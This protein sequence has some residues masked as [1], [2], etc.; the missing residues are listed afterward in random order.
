MPQDEFNSLMS[1]EKG[2]SSAWESALMACESL[3][4]ISENMKTMTKLNTTHETIVK[5][6]SA[7]NKDLD[8]FKVILVKLE[9]L[10]DALMMFLFPL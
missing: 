9:N 10:S 3:H 1:G 2:F 8:E 7:M 6:I 5:N 4:L